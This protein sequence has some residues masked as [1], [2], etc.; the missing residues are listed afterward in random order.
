MLKEKYVVNS[1]V[2]LGS[3]VSSSVCSKSTVG[4]LLQNAPDVSP[5][6]FSC[7]VEMKPEETNSMDLDKNDSNNFSGII[8]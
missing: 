1:L 7:S 8:F 4:N 6:S 5:N 3:P 2:S